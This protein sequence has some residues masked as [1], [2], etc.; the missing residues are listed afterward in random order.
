MYIFWSEILINLAFKNEMEFILLYRFYKNY[1]L[2]L[3]LRHHDI[4]KS[5]IMLV[6]NSSVFRS[7]LEKKY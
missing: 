2:Y 1:T 6:T 5:K 3:H 4:S 7:T